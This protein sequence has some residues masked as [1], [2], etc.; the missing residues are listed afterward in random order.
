MKM[1]WEIE[2]P[3]F[4]NRFILQGLALAIGIPFG[5]LITAIVILAKG[6][7]MG[8]D[9]KYALF[10]IGLLFLL[11]YLFIMLIYGGRYAP[12]FIM[13]EE[14]IT[15]Y[16]QVTQAQKNKLINLL[17]IIL[18]L[19]KGN[20][21]AAGSGLMAQ[22]RQVMQI[23]WKNISKIRYYP[24][25]YTIIIKGGFAEKIALFCTKENYSQ[26]ATLIHEKHS[27]KVI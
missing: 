15:N 7:I 14:G 2:V 25:H 18:G 6:D 3:L 4:K 27:M 23:K 21:A 10:L 8:T 1:Q 16:T 9:A 11:T 24:K 12:G 17:V 19:F 20:Y 22:S 13:D 5:L 26:V